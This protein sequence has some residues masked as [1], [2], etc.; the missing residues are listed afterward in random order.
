[1]NRRTRCCLA[2]HQ[3]D[4]ASKQFGSQVC[5]GDLGTCATSCHDEFLWFTP[6]ADLATRCGTTNA[7]EVNSRTQIISPKLRCHQLIS[8]NDLAVRNK[9]R[10]RCYF[11]AIVCCSSRLWSLPF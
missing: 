7:P 11:N 10:G 5:N 8:F 2:A 9:E 3:K 1:M 4:V 6:I